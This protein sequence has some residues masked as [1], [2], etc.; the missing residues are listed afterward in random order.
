AL[1]I[2]YSTVLGGAGGEQGFGI[3]LDSSGDA[4]VT[5][6]TGS[7]DFP[8]TV[9]AFDTS[10]HGGGDAFVTKLDPTGSALLY[11]TYLGG[12]GEDEGFGITLDSAGDAY[13][14]GVTG[15]R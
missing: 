1:P 3:A 14:T 4:Y 8:T 2:F 12:A 9:G 6:F 5:G 13:G 15:A 11:S 7:S 10:Y